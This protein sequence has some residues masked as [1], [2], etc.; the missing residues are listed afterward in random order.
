M[1]QS[2]L[3]VKAL[4]TIAILMNRRETW[5]VITYGD[6]GRP[7]GQPPYGLG[8]IL[9]RVGCWCRSVGKEE[10]AMLVIDEERKP[11]QG[12]YNY[13][14]GAT[15]RSRQKPYDKRRVRLWRESW[16]G[17]RIPTLEQ[18]ANAYAAER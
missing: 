11:R 13:P 12:M 5:S 3:D 10:L 8:D 9:D 16:D 7:L 2:P 6:L 18:I 4:A 14:V 1:P 17:V 15:D